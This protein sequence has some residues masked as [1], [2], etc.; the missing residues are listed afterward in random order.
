[1]DD[2]END[3]GTALMRLRQAFGKHGIPCPDVLEYSDGAK[4]YK[5]MAPLRHALGPANWGMTSASNP[6]GEVSLAGFSL[7][8][9]P[10]KIEYPGTGQQL[11]DGV[12]GRIFKD[13]LKE[14]PDGRDDS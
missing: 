11:D 9:E 2:I 12:S 10:R 6:V 8:F 1:M 4:A 3:I 5:A 7:R 13:D 14:E